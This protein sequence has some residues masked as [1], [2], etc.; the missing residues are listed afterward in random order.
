MK[1]IIV[2]AFA[3]VLF[4]VSGCESPDQ[5]IFDEVP[6]PIALATTDP[7]ALAAFALTAYK[8]L[9]GTW[10]G[11]N[12]LWSMQ[13]VSSD[14]MT[15]A[16]KGG[17]W[18]DGN[19]W[20]RM[21]EHGYLATEESIGNGWA[22]CFSAIATINNTLKAFGTSPLL[23]AELETLRAMVYLWLIDAYGNVPIIIETSTDPTPATRTRQEV[24]AFIESSIT[25]NLANLPKTKTYGTVNWYVAQAILAKLYLNA[26][27]YAGTP[28][29]QKASA[30]CEAIIAGGLYSLEANY[31]DNFKADNA[32]SKENIFVINYD[33]VNGTG[34]NLAQMTLHYS[35]QATFNLAAQP[36]N[37]YASLE[38][39]YNSYATADTRRNSFLAGPQF[40]STGV[41]LTDT[42][43]E[44]GAFGDPDGENLTFTPF[45]AAVK[46][47][48]GVAPFGSLRQQGVRVGKFQFQTGATP[49]LSNDFPIFRYGDILLMKAEALWRLNAADANALALVNQIRSRAGVPA[50]VSLTEVALL[51]ERGREMFAEGYRRSD[52]IRFGKY[53]EAW[54]EKPVSAPSK[55][56][57]PIPFNQTL[58]NPKLVQNP[59]Y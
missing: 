14:E 43:F 16:I 30:A 39:F 23:R 27:I 18:T 49:D 33:Q 42:S 21:H 6:T 48:P 1:K 24:Y 19:S 15:I 57:F 41:R 54:W 29:L 50:L 5:L 58:V 51:A 20:T 36:W 38:E 46:P 28:Q 53:N 13:E 44:T 40:S 35:S 7:T 31:F 45:I 32:G 56:I 55:N 37:G 22:Y 17:D 47:K 34:F 4:L 12:S 59:G 9:V 8:P 3:L 52:L 11:H 10:G 26:G 25:T 2:S